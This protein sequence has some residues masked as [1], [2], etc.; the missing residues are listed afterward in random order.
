MK[1]FFIK[2]VALPVWA[3]VL[4]GFLLVGVGAASNSPEDTEVATENTT[5]STTSTTRPTSTLILTTTTTVPTTTTI[6]TTTTAP[7]TTTTA[8]QQP[9]EVT[10]FS[11][12]SSKNTPSFKVDGEWQINWNVSGG[13]GV[14]IEVLSTDGGR[15]SY[16]SADPGQDSSVLR[17]SCTCYLDIT[18]FGSTYN[19]AVIELP[20]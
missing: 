6:P 18:P 15:L 4:G 12:S 16:I 5:A 3:L 13:A 7:T 20:G 17:E 2:R 8:P 14:G 10:R 1:Q 9:R 11:G 19:I